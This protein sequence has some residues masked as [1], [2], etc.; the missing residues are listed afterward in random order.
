MKVKLLPTCAQVYINF[1]L[2]NI[3]KTIKSLKAK[4]LPDFVQV[5]I[6][7]YLLMVVRI[8]GA[9]RDVSYNV[10]EFIIQKLFIRG[11]IYCT[12]I[13]EDRTVVSM[14]TKP[15]RGHINFKNR[16][17]YK[18]DFKYSMLTVE[19]RFIIPIFV[20]SFIFRYDSVAPN[21]PY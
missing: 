15:E 10:A 20:K 11:R 4:L 18:A 3:A 7:Y 19:K 14:Y 8:L 13:K 16:E 21:K 12:F 5:Y 2:L 17:W 1:Y 6:N 9:L